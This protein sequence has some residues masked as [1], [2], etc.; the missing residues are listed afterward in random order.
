[1]KGKIQTALASFGMSGRVFHGPLL[2]VVP[3]FE[4]V[5]VLERSNNNSGEMFPKAEIVRSY[6]D[7][8]NDKA[9]ELIVVNTPDYLHFEMAK[10]ALDAGKHVV[11]EKPF[12]QTSTQAKELIVLAMKKGALLTVYQNRRWD[13]DFCTVKKVV[14]EKMVDRLAEFESHYDRYRNFITPDTW[15][16]EGGETGG[17]L[18][19]LGSHMIDQALLLFGKPE[20]V[21]CHL[22]ILR[23]GGKV[24]DYYDIRFQYNGFAALLKCSYLVREPGPRYIIHGTD[25]SFLKWGIDPQEEALK[26]GALPIGDD[27]GKEP[28]SD[29][30]LL[31]SETKGVHKKTKIETIPGDYKLFYENVYRTIREGEGLAVKPE[32]ALLSIEMIEACLKSHREKRTMKV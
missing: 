31:S 9:V 23:E 11:V 26:A 24:A 27:W 6:D 7:I 29:W 8:L 16:E 10:A 4:V 18:F 12:T 20:S 25:G 1:M 21:T 3:G 32:E 22:A 30:G 14:E 15:K 5:K 13:G 2:K 28:E 17:V 19:N